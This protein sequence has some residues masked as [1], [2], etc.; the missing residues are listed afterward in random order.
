LIDKTST[1]LQPG[2]EMSDGGF[3]LLICT[4]F[5][6]CESLKSSCAQLQIIFKGA[7]PFFILKEGHFITCWKI[8]N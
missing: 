4:L 1:A 5:L 3:I 8:I 7:Y 6:Y 2:S